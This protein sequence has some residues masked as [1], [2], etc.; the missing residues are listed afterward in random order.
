MDKL[1]SGG[2]LLGATARLLICEFDQDEKNAEAQKPK[3][4]SKTEQAM[5]EVIQALLD[6]GFRPDGHTQVLIVRVP[7]RSSPV[8]GRTGGEL[9]KFG[10]R[11]RFAKPGTTVK[12][13]VGARTTA[14][15]RI[16]GK[17]LEGVHG[18]ASVDTKNIEAVRAALLG[19]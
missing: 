15:Y 2:G 9:A 7:S 6:A 16:D 3:K 8:F 17:G 14:I 4:V 10:G 12:S 5:G 1:P 19:L 11:Q 13:T 18:I